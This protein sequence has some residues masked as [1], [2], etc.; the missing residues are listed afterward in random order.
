M[1]MNLLHV[2]ATVT[3][4]HGGQATVRPG[5]SRVAVSSQPVAVQT[6]VYTIAGCGFTVSGSPHPCVTI[7]WVQPST[8]IRVNGVPALLENSVGL[9]LAADQA[10]QGPP[11]VITVQRRAG[12][13]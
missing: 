12:G 8:A 9:C 4:P 1:S 5:Q 11:R 7:R 13:R 2:N 3:C 6:D 10:P